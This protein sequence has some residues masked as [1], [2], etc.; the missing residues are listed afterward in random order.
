MRLL[1]CLLTGVII[2]SCTNQLSDID[3]QS[4]SDVIIFD[5]T[6]VKEFSAYK[7]P[8]IPQKLDF[9][10]ELI[11]IEDVDVKERLDRELV[12]N[13]F[14]HS[15]TIFYLKKANRWYPEIKNILVEEG[16]PLDFFYLAVI[17]SGLMQVTSPSGAKG[18]WQFMPATAKEFGLI[19]NEYIDERMHIEKSTRA[20]CK[21]L[22]KAYD[23][24][25]S[26]VLAAAAYNRGS[27]GII[28]DQN[29]QKMTNFFDLYLNTETSRYVF[30]IIAAKII[31]GE[32]ENLVVISQK[33]QV[34]Q[35]QISQIPKL[36]RSTQGVRLMRLD[37]GDKV[38]SVTCL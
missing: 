33:G 9:A 25:G 22:N 30:R 12:V 32:E 5:T 3:V 18:I 31:S 26:W 13:N 10:G 34:I 16:V 1:F 29:R 35:T 14:W 24:F 17:E 8:F 36:S 11:P 23:K 37:Q 20:A 38:A 15:N 27:A 7:A 28:A 21:Y 2:C 6:L 4:S 19:V